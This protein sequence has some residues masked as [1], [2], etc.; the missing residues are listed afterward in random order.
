MHFSGS[1][2]HS[3]DCVSSPYVEWQRRLPVLSESEEERALLQVPVTVQAVWPLGLHVITDSV[4]KGILGRKKQCGAY[5]KL[6]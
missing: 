2:F 6:Q 1:V 3:Y 4:I 5:Y